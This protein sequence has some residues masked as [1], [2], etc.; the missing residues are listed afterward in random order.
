MEYKKKDGISG[1]Y[2]VFEIDCASEESV[3]AKMLQNNNIC[4]LLAC[5]F[6]YEDNRTYIYYDTTD[7]M[8]VSDIMKEGKMT[9]DILKEIY[10]AIAEILK[11][12]QKYL[13]SADSVLL[14]KDLIFGNRK[15]KN[16]K[17]CV[18]PG[19]NCS[20]RK[21]IKELTEDFMK[22][23]DHCDKKCVEFMYGIYDIVS[24][25]NFNMVDIEEFLKER[26]YPDD[27]SQY[28][29]ETS[30]Y[31]NDTSRYSDEMSRYQ[32]DTSRYP[33]EAS[34]YSDEVSQFSDK[35]SQRKK[36][37]IFADENDGV[38][39]FSK[40]K[41]KDNAGDYDKSECF[42]LVR[43]NKKNNFFKEFVPEI[44]NIKK[45]LSFSGDMGSIVHIGRSRDNDIVFPQNYI[46]RKH[47]VLEADEN[48]LYVTDK[49]SC[50]GTLVNGERIAANVKT[51][52]RVQDEI[53]F[54]DICFVVVFEIEK[55]LKSE[56]I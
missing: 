50:N 19:L 55:S 54:A 12:C 56:I 46:S 21:Q 33:D 48:F 38:N 16:L 45:N 5:D 13:I 20:F 53:T 29:D 10:T 6:R 4:G 9:Y 22:I 35:T 52:C 25:D 37:N 15:Y 23:T 39:V 1:V 3:E 17:F 36:S 31:Q 51:R 18:L 27:V 2:I 47:A 42:L 40:S 34:W 24:T 7:K 11:S 28:S 8:A 32:N 26:Q 30:W 43:E 41:E 44:I 49:G 14:N